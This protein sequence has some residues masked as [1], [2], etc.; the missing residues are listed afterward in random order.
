[1]APPVGGFG[2]VR[3]FVDW[4]LLPDL[5]ALG[6][7]PSAPTS[8]TKLIR[9]AGPITSHMADPNLLGDDLCDYLAADAWALSNRLKLFR[10]EGGYGR[11][12]AG[13]NVA[14]LA[15]QLRGGAPEEALRAL[16]ETL[17]AQVFEH[18]RDPRGTSIVTRLHR[19]IEHVAALDEPLRRHAP[20]LLLA[21]LQ[22]LLGALARGE[23][24]W[25]TILD[26]LDEVRRAAARQLGAPSTRRL[27]NIRDF[28]DAVTAFYWRLAEA[29]SAAPLMT[30]T[31]GRANAMLLTFTGL[32][33]LGSPMGP[34]QQLTL[35]APETMA[36]PAPPGE[37]AILIGRD[38]TT[39]WIPPLEVE[40]AIMLLYQTA[41]DDFRTDDHIFRRLG[42]DLPTRARTG[43]RLPFTARTEA[44]KLHHSRWMNRALGME[45]L[46]ACAL[47]AIDAPNW[48]RSYCL[49]RNGH[50]SYFAQGGSFDVLASYGTS[51]HGPTF[52]V[53]AEASARSYRN[54]TI[55]EYKKQLTEGVTHARQV[56]GQE[57]NDFSK[58]YVLIPNVRDI[59][60]EDEV[61]AAYKEV[62]A[63]TGIAS[64]RRIEL[65]PMFTKD[66]A[67]AADRINYAYWDATDQFGAGELALVLDAH[68]ALLSQPERPDDPG[69]MRGIWQQAEDPP[70]F[71]GVLAPAAPQPEP[72]PQGG[73]SP[74]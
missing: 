26:R 55:P 27:T 2:L 24:P 5:L 50:P 64:D 66:L 43:S 36:R 51:G 6:S 33:G 29:S 12:S 68:V 30:E 3:A 73:M 63:E 44:R 34:A 10:P 60:M 15:V 39:E 57:G 35:P 22:F 70:R 20:G 16:G 71:G 25:G 61:W 31:E 7:G 74:N 67:Y 54:L 58:I 28:A 8:W 18:Y 38:E 14:K 53:G 11:T 17:G 23:L 21:E 9:E 19:A 69:W 13:E 52:A 40:E 47:S 48:V 42:I 62:V 56:L 65:I 59:C 41:E 72:S 49:V 46:T 37:G 4:A 1:M 32:L 45:L